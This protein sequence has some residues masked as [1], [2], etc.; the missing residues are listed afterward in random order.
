MWVALDV[1]ADFEQLA[2]VPVG[3]LDPEGEGDCGGYYS[4]DISQI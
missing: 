1:E 3:G 4:A 2:D